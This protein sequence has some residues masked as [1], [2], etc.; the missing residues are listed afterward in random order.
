M[1]TSTTTPAMPDVHRQHRRKEGAV[2][3]DETGD[4]ARP[5]SPLIP[6]SLPQRPRSKLRLLEKTETI[7]TIATEVEPTEPK[8]NRGNLSQRI[9]TNSN[10]PGTH[11]HRHRR[12]RTVPPKHPTNHEPRRRDLFR[13][14]TA[15]LTAWHSMLLLLTTWFEA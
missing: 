11:R 8:F 13:P 14:M 2:P 7:F 12:S 6:T 4:A 5:K 10:H 15:T 1:A 9:Q 3:L